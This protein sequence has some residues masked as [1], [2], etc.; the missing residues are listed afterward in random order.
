MRQVVHCTEH[1]FVANRYDLA[2]RRLNLDTTG[3]AAK[4]NMAE[5]H[6]AAVAH[7]AKLPEGD[8]EVL[9]LIRYVVQ[10]WRMPSCPR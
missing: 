6:D 4:A 7:I 5:K 1:L 8:L 9:Q 10:N 2:E 3:P